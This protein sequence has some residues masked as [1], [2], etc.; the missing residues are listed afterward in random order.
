V[1]LGS[2]YKVSK[3]SMLRQFHKRGVQIRDWNAERD[4]ELRNRYVDGKKICP[5]C[6]KYKG[7]DEFYKDVSRL[8]R[9]NRLCKGCH[10]ERCKKY[11]NNLTS[12]QIKHR[13]EHGRQYRQSEKGKRSSK[14][15]SHFHSRMPGGRLCNSR[16]RARR[17][18]IGW[19]IEKTDYFELIKKSC[20]Y[21]GGPLPTAG[22]GLDR[23]DNGL[24]YHLNN[25]VPCCTICNLSRRNH[26]TPEEMKRFIGPAIRSVRE[27]RM[28]DWKSIIESTYSKGDTL[29]GKIPC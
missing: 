3:P 7:P 26:F 25:V 21:C 11:K 20:S 17:I 8:D 9:L 2:L 29:K 24:G 16:S 5:E 13:R 27:A 1:K 23:L 14:S 10:K 28:T 15:N 22:A 12:E 6:K 19:T 4:M 18:G